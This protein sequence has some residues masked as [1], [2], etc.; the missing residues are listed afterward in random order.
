MSN[1]FEECMDP[2]YRFKE[3]GGSK[4]QVQKY[5]KGP[6]IGKKYIKKGAKKWI[7]CIF[8]GNLNKLDF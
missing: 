4:K 2:K 5:Y 3:L 1:N 7:E 6:A 8:F